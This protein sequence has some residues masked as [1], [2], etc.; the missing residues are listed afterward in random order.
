MAGDHAFIFKLLVHRNSGD[1]I[2][3]TASRIDIDHG[4]F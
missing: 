4:F 3:M 1:Y 2:K